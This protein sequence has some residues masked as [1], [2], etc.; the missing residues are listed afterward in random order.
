MFVNSIYQ[1]DYKPFVQTLVAIAPR[2]QKDRLGP[3]GVRAARVPHP[4]LRTV[5]GGLP[6]RD[7]GLHG[8]ELLQPGPRQG[9][10]GLHLRGRIN[11][12][13]DKVGNVVET[14]RP[15]K[16]NA[17][18]LDVIKKETRCSTR[19]RSWVMWWSCKDGDE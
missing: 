14:S 3:H 5:P 16:K 7:A 18:Y 12:K 19:C 4:R 15:D 11:A 9:A 8:G 1:C 2:V 17:Q 6:Q 10:A 13:I